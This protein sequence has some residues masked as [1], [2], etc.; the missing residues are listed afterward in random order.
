MASPSADAHANTLKFVFPR[1]GLI[2]TAQQ[3]LDAAQRR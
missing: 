2:R 3:V 1:L